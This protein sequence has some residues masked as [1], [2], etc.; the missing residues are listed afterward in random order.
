MG[1]SEKPGCITAYT[2]VKHVSLSHETMASKYYIPYFQKLLRI[3]FEFADY[4]EKATE[5]IDGI[6]RHYGVH[7][8]HLGV[9]SFGRQDLP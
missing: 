3:I 9:Q 5:P 6:A 8:R 2:S 4:I 1:Q 7:G